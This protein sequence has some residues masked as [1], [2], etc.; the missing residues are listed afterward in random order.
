M[1]T[2]GFFIRAC[3]RFG[4]SSCYLGGPWFVAAMTDGDEER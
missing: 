3:M 1:L 4:L 2:A